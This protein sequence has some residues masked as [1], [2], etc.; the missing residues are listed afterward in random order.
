LG[1]DNGNGD[2]TLTHGHFHFV[3]KCLVDVYFGELR[4]M[5]FD[6]NIRSVDGVHTVLGAVSLI[7]LSD[8]QIS[9]TAV[10]HNRTPAC[11][12]FVPCSPS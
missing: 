7:L 11:Q 6:A 8:P 10:G 4:T 5:Y 9:G 2:Y 1:I 12:L 3:R